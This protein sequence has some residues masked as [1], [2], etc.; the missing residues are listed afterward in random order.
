MLVKIY[1]FKDTP[2]S[3]SGGELDWISL[4]QDLYQHSGTL[5]LLDVF[6]C[7]PHTAVLDDHLILCVLS[8][9]QTFLLASISKNNFSP[10]NI[11]LSN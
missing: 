9:E 3:L 7:H 1:D 11:W 8:L 6:D 2:K 5:T 4:E 10:N